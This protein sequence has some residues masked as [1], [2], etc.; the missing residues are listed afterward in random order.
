[1]FQRPHGGCADRYDAPPAFYRAVDFFSVLA[2][3]RIAL[4]VHPV[5]LYLFYV[6]GLKGSKANM[7]RN[8][9]GFDSFLAQAIEDFRREMQSRRRRGDRPS[10]ARIYRLVTLA[11]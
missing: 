3:N 5:F 8:F 6:Y 1:M 4:R 9:S 10:L 2:G 7:K 11:V